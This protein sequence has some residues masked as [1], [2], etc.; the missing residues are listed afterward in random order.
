MGQV[1]SKTR[2]PGQ[3]LGNSSLHF[4]GQICDLM[5]MKLGQNVCLSSL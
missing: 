5:L 1:G 2:S 4:R 3:I